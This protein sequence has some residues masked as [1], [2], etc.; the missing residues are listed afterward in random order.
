VRDVAVVIPAGGL[1][2]RLGLRTPKQ[3][4]TLGRM[5]ILAI[6][7]RHFARRRDV[8]AV[9]VAAPPGHVARARRALARISS[10]ASLTVVA[11]GTTRQESVSL[12]LAA[13]PRAEVIVVHDAVR[14]FITDAL[15]DRVLAAARADGA[16]VCALPIAETV[17]RVRD[18]VVEATIDRAGLWGVQ[19]PQAF[20]AHLLR[21][22][23][24]KARRDGVVGTDDAMLVERLGVSVRVVDGLPQNVKITT[25]ADLARARR[26]AGR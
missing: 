14:P 11:G 20:R 8:A 3:F 23:H 2:T 1:G 6:T 17:K 15:I 22:A 7:T 9:I 24:D 26:R 18:G 5:S 10:R 16:A 12:G 4:L 19:T 25:P 13:A 21:E